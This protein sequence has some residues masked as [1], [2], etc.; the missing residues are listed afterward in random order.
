MLSSYLSRCI[1]REKRPGQA[2][3]TASGIIIQEPSSC[4][5]APLLLGCL[6]RKGFWGDGAAGTWSCLK[7]GTWPGK[8]AGEEQET[9]PPD[10]VSGSGGQGGRKCRWQESTRTCPL[11]TD[12]FSTVR[13]AASKHLYSQ[14]NQAEGRR[15]S[16][17]VAGLLTLLP[18]RSGGLRAT[19]SWG[20]S[21]GLGQSTSQP[22]LGFLPSPGIPAPLGVRGVPGRGRAKKLRETSAGCLR[23][24]LWLS[25]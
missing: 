8:G 20:G 14:L 25:L 15:A 10:C 5:T 1:W 3:R 6:T 19:P 11:M 23:T 16:W 17:S 21:Q 13:Q 22:H 12:A 7:K 9:P 24:L 2:T 4:R 18:L